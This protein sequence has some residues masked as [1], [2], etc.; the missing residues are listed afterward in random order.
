MDRRN[1]P[2]ARATAGARQN[3]HSEEKPGTL[4]GFYEKAKAPAGIATDHV[5]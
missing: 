1:D 4:T 2:H 5:E 3:V